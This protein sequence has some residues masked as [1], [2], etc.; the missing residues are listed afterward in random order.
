MTRL[1]ARRSAPASRSPVLPALPRYPSLLEINTRVWLRRLA[2]EAARPISL[3]DIDDAVLDD[4]ARQGFD[5]VWLLSIWQTGLA[6]RAI[7][8]RRRARSPPPSLLPA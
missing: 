2:P 8:R 4:L 6:G 7:S 3:A 5:W 1:A